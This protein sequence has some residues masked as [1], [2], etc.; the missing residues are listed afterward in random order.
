MRGSALASSLF[1]LIAA[2]CDGDP[3]G[4]SCA[5]GEVCA[6]AAGVCR[7]GALSGPV[8]EDGDTCLP[9]HEACMPPIPEPVCGT[10][11]RWAPGQP[12]F[13]DA[14]DA[15]GLT[16]VLGVRLSVTDVDGDG[17][18]DLEVRRGSLGPD[19][20]DDPAGRRTWLLRNTGAGRFEDI[21]QASDLL[22]RRAPD[23]RGRPVSIVAWGDVDG[24]GDLDVYT[25]LDT[26]DPAIAVGETSE[27]L[28]NDGAGT[29]TLG[30]A[31]N[32]VRRASEGDIPA[33]ASFVDV[34]H[35]GHLD[36]F[37]PQHNSPDRKSVV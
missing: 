17:W 4:G 12:A 8:C 19:D 26:T 24:D 23:G 28:L 1:F 7:C 15:W 5:A 33:G 9:D 6:P 13:R 22:S 18:A 20:F 29:F 27:I 11:T 31:D 21:T 10:G 3:C 25:G 14:T 35:D 2:G 16:G 34:D 36:L 37:V 30:P 32:P